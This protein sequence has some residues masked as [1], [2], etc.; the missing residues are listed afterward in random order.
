MRNYKEIMIYK[1]L[2]LSHVVLKIYFHKKVENFV[3]YILD[4]FLHRFLIL[5]SYEKSAAPF[6]HN[7]ERV[8]VVGITTL[9]FLTGLKLS[10][11]KGLNRSF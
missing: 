2:K 11:S 6:L 7:S 1:L 9:I 10:Q 5:I 4:L 3:Q 8:P